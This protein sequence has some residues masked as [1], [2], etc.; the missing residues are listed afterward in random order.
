MS[1]K[2]AL[3]P[4]QKNLIYSRLLLGSTWSEEKNLEKSQEHKT[5]KVLSHEDGAK[6]SFWMS[7]DVRG[8]HQ[9]LVLCH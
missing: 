1:G 6:A 9:P 8:M 3:S 5:Q 2:E 4:L 7:R